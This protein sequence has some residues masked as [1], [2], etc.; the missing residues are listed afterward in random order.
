MTISK[1]PER[2]SIALIGPS[3]RFLS[4][5]SYFTILLS[6][7]LSESIDVRVILFRNMLPKNLFPGWKRVGTD[8]SN[9]QFNRGIQTSEVLDW[10]NPLSWVYG[11]AQAVKNDVII[12]QWWTSS[13]AHMYLAIALF[14]LKNKPIIIE[15]HETVDQLEKGIY[16]LRL[17]A[18]LMATILRY[19]ADVY[20]THSEYDKKLVCSSYRIKEEKIR[21][22]PLGLFDQYALIDRNI[23]KE[24]LGLK[25]KKIV[26]F[27]GLLRP[28]KGV[29]YLIRAFEQLPEDLVSNTRLL[30]VGEV[31]EDNESRN[32]YE[33][34]PCKSHITLV[35]RYVSDDEISAF[36]SS[37]N[38]L[39]IPY[40]RASQSGV[41]H[42]GMTFGLPIVASKVGGLIESLGAYEGIEFFTPGNIPELREAIIR[43][44]A[45]D[46]K[47]SPPEEVKW[48]NVAAIWKS[49]IMSLLKK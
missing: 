46:K 45:T 47:F 43:Q 24:M 33:R 23:A 34:S 29:K 3:Q 28:Y 42:I 18:K 31:W 27:F 17:Y 11:A 5:I 38:V 20:V 21:V 16:P 6:N 14:N 13:V 49:I 39:V 26:L 41:A 36:F 19:L 4:G 25:E 1:K 12:F 40:V 7:A 30:I 9:I 22:V 15:F 35:D 8:L 2:I 44:L 37:A 10:Y 32:I 48:N